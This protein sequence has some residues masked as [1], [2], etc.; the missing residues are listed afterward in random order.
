MGASIL[1]ANLF[2]IQLLRRHLLSQH[3][4]KILL[5][6]LRQLQLAVKSR[7]PR[8]RQ[9]MLRESRENLLQMNDSVLRKI[10]HTFL[11]AH[12]KA[13]FATDDDLNIYFGT[14][15]SFKK[16]NQLLDHPLVSL[17]VV[18]EKLDPLRVVDMRGVAKEVPQEHTKE[19]LAH[20]KSKNMSK[21]FVEGAEDFV[22]FRIE[23]TQMRW[24]DA[25]SGELKIEDVPL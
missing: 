18:E 17:S 3:L 1:S 8:R 23:P 5:Q 9:L 25:T 21:Y 7:R 24:L 13:V 12:K 11:D 16:Y 15:K 22:M 20:F 14:R 6:A 4:Q 10:V 19:V 2:K